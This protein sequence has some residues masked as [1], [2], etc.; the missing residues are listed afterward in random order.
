MIL[1]AKSNTGYQNLIQLITKGHIESFY[2][3]PRLDKELLVQ[4]REGLIALS[5][6]LVEEYAPYSNGRRGEA[7]QAAIGYQQI[8]G[9]D[10]YLEAHATSDPRT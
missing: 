1:L 4:Y 2:Y 9:D 8:F 5:A 10:F 7:K 3:K 6:C